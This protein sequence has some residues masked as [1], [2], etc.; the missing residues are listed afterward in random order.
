M[1]SK[2]IVCSAPR[3]GCERQ[4]KLSIFPTNTLNVFYYAPTFPFRREYEMDSSHF[5]SKLDRK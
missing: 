1:N 2:T 4:K 5:Y 3:G